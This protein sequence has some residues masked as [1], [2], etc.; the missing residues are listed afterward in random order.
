MMDISVVIPVFNEEQSIRE[1]VDNIKQVLLTS[2]NVGHFEIIVVNDAS[3]D[4]TTEKISDCADV[5]IMTSEKRHGYGQALKNGIRRASYD[6]IV[7]TDGDGS[8]ETEKIS[9]L[10]DTITQNDLVIGRRHY[11][12]NSTSKMRILA[13]SLLN[14]VSSFFTHQ[15]V[16]DV[17]SGMRIFRKYFITQYMDLF[18]SGFSFTT[19]CTLIAFYTGLRIAYVPVDYYR[20]RGCSKIRAR[21]FFIILYT[22]I[23]ITYAFHPFRVF[24]VLAAILICCGLSLW[25][26][27]SVYCWN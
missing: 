1:T 6:I 4:S 7:I 19:T 21:D 17:N 18:P 20:R 24:T 27:L 22:V 25:G 2:R 15:K 13:R 11:L 9:L 10:V 14:K 5:S 3:L 16:Y 26:L 8:Y 12:P 23:K